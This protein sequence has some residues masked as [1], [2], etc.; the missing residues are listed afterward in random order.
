MSS[1]ETFRKAA[2]DPAEFGKYYLSHYFTRPSPPFHRQLSG[3]WRRRVMKNR[4][5]VSDCAAILA[6]K[7]TRSAVAAP[8]GHAKS[9]VMSLQNVLH[10]AL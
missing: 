3:L 1:T 2:R 8:R 4:D 7:G 9:T 5:P 10:A 6:D